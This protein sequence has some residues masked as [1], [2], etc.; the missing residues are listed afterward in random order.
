MKNSLHTFSNGIAPL[1]RNMSAT[2]GQTFP[3]LR[4]LAPPIHACC[5]SIWYLMREHAL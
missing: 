5:Q 3:V 1:V 4:G 2:Y